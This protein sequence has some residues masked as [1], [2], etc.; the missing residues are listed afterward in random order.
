M[1]RTTPE[2]KFMRRLLLILVLLMAAGVIGYA[3]MRPAT[4]PPMAGG[5][6]RGA[7]TAGGQPVP[8][9]AA[10]A[11]RRDVPIYLDGLGTVQAYYNVT[12]KAMIDGPLTQV[13]FRE[14]QDVHVGDV[15]AR[16]DPRPYQAALDQA[17][18]KKAQDEATL[19]NA[20]LDLVR[21]TKL[22]QTA[23]TSAQTADTQRALVAQTEA[24]VKQDQAQIDNA[25]TQLSYTTITSPIDGRTGIRGVDPGNIVHASDTTGIV[26]ITTLQ[27]ISVVFT[28][29]QQTLPEV[30]AAMQ[31]GKP[32]V[33]ALPQG[34]TDTEAALDRGVLEVIDN[35]VDSTTGTIR[36]KA[37]FPNPNHTLWPGG[38]V[39]V[40][41]LVNTEH[42]VLTVPPVAIQRGPQGSFVYVVNANDTVTRRT[43]TVGH[44]DSTESV[45]TAGLQAGDR[46]VTEGASR[47]TDAAKVQVNTPP[48]ATPPP[49]AATPAPV[50]HGGRGRR[51]AAEN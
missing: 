2:G 50:H 9:L 35:Q 25:R 51:A 13:L 14:G 49:T 16:I 36:L 17:V 4:H 42:N 18:A 20:R 6:R 27:P 32:E 1:P 29:P 38:F 48:S 8:V 30:N 31:A 15:L 47:L 19:A 12:V 10:A 33:V 24:L 3:V 34:I 43:V 5:G 44:E 22:A 40:R 28:L 7:A 23:Y 21:Y 46:V 45:V 11:E 39:N 26:V 37:T 41:L